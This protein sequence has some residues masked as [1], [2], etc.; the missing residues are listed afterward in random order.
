[1]RLARVSLAVLAMA[2]DSATAH[3]AFDDAL[4]HL[5]ANRDW[6]NTWAAIEAL[7]IHWTKTGR[8]EPAA[9]LLGH[10]EARTSTTYPS[11]HSDKTPLPPYG[12]RPRHSRGWHEAAHSTATS[13]LTTHSTNWSTLPTRSRSHHGAALSRPPRPRSHPTHRTMTTRCTPAN[14]NQPTRSGGVICPN[15]AV[16]TPTQ[17]ALEV[18]DSAVPPMGDSQL[19]SATLS[20]LMR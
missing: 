17:P 14:H 12:K 15:E 1:M 7:A 18:H 4:T 2:S 5:Y 3:V 8:T 11:S 9:T 19:D 10:L 20:D 16:P 13:S 6:A